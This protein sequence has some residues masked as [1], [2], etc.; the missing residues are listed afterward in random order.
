MTFHRSMDLYANST[1]SLTI[2]AFFLTPPFLTEMLRSMVSIC[3]IVTSKALMEEHR[4]LGRRSG[5]HHEHKL[6]R[7]RTGPATYA[8]KRW[9]SCVIYSVYPL[10]DHYHEKCVTPLS[11]SVLDDH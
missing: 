3:P 9:Y 4:R 7:G 10:W 2:L 6:I 11:I 8:R 5:K 1:P